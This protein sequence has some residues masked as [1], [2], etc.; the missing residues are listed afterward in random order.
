MCECLQHHVNQY[1]YNVAYSNRE[2]VFWGKK[3]LC[4]QY[5]LSA[6]F[7]SQPLNTP[8][9]H[10]TLGIY[11]FVNVIYTCSTTCGLHIGRIVVY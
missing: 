3:N 1:M 10:N 2:F 6:R 11:T 7:S 8:E 4:L 9:P 5:N